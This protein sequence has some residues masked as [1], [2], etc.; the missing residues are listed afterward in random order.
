MHQNMLASVAAGNQAGQAGRA[1]TVQHAADMHA[2]GW[3]MS[4]S[5]S[6]ATVGAGALFVLVAVSAE[7][8]ASLGLI[9]RTGGRRVGLSG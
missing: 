6:Q 8:A 9:N 2:H 5:Q 4:Q 1:L 3:S 7:G